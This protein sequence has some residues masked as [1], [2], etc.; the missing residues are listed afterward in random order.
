VLAGSVGG[1]AGVALGVLCAYPLTRVVMVD[2]L[3]WSL[4]VGV[5]LLKL[6]VLLAA[7]VLASLSASVYPAWLSRR[8]VTREPLA[9]EGCFISASRTTSAPCTSR[10]ANPYPVRIWRRSKNA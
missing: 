2:A 1:L 8:A 10:A 4:T 5:D 9:P 7:V 6:V 3:G